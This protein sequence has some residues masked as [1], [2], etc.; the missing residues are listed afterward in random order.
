V[1]AYQTTEERPGERSR[2]A[3]P[4]A[5]P[6]LR[7]GAITPQAIMALQSTAGNSATLAALGGKKP[8][9]KPDEAVGGR[10]AGEFLGDI[11][12]PIGTGLGD[13]VGGI[14]GALG[15]NS[16]ST[17][18]LVKP[19]WTK[20]GQFDWGIAWVTSGRSG[21]IVQEV[22]ND[23]RIQDAAG[24][25]IPSPATPHYWEAWEVDAAGGATPADH[26]GNDDWQRPDMDASSG[27]NTS[28]HWSMRGVVY[29]ADTD[30]ATQGFASGNVPD[31][32]ILLSTTTAPTGLGV[33]RDF[34]YA[35][36]HW[37]STV[38]KPYH[39]GSAR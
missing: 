27:G 14:A 8:D 34:R 38:A 30:P 37:D 4:P 29:W 26:R 6:E 17:N 25:A 15:G 16:I 21:W 35:Q 19:V 12:R 10:T 3:S 36:G 2:E 7:P 31:A 22:I 11:A 5:T 18:D 32:G 28:G 23:Y 20:G 33:P 13:I 24:A 9:A 1:R 39:D